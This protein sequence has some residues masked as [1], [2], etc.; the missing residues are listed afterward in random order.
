MQ[1]LFAVAVMSFFV[2][3]APFTESLTK[4]LLEN[5]NRVMIKRKLFEEYLDKANVI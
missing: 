3:S 1:Q 2:F 5:G 4:F